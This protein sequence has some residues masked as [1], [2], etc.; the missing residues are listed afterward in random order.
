MLI[1]RMIFSYRIRGLEQRDRLGREQ[2][3]ADLGQRPH[4]PSHR[5]RHRLDSSRLVTQVGHNYSRA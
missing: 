1:K 5:N 2:G 3:V 4:R